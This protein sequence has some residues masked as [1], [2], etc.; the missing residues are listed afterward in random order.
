MLLYT[1]KL[2]L[3]KG[4][5]D[6]L[7]RFDCMNVRVSG[8]ARIGFLAGCLIFTADN[9]KQSSPHILYSIRA[10]NHRAPELWSSPISANRASPLLCFA[11]SPLTWTCWIDVHWIQLWRLF[12]NQWTNSAA[13][14]NF[15]SSISRAFKSFILQHL[16][17]LEKLLVSITNNIT[18]CFT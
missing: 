12:A 10:V 5:A 17:R 1:I 6:L 14:P 15:S 2:R 11:Y 3:D 16:R 18:L 7:G 4:S 8:V 9:T 13:I